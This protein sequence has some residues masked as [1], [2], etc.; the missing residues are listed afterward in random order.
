MAKLRTKKQQREYIRPRAYELAKSGKFTSWH[1]IEVHLR[2]EEH[3]PEARHVLD[4]PDIRE[5]LDRL[6]KESRDI[7]Q[8]TD[9]RHEQR[10]FIEITENT[11]FT[12]SSGIRQ[13]VRSAIRDTHRPPQDKPDEKSSDND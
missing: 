12:K 8:E 13:K 11:V 1:Q 4:A 10:R 6:C 9:K 7:Q 3:C 2:S 5:K